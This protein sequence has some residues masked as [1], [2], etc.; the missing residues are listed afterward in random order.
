MRVSTSAVDE[1]EA[2]GFAALSEDALSGRVVAGDASSVG[3]LVVP[4][5]VS[6]PSSA[7][8]ADVV[9]V[10]ASGPSACASPA[11][12]S[13]IAASPALASSPREQSGDKTPSTATKTQTPG[14]TSSHESAA[15]KRSRHASRLRSLY[16]THSVDAKG[17][18]KSGHGANSG[19]V[20]PSRSR[21]LAH[22][23]RNLSQA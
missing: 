10:C 4:V 16:E 15:S 9:P 19:I 6:P 18:I 7:G 13:S 20:Q 17:R 1:P 21:W 14:T 23:F 2:S 8:P 12:A 22:P 11:E 3:A 5:R